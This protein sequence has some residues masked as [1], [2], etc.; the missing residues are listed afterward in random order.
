[1]R[2]LQRW[3]R[4]W[5]RACRGGLRPAGDDRSRADGVL[6]PSPMSGLTR[7]RWPRPNWQFV[8]GGLRGSHPPPWSATSCTSRRATGMV[9]RA[10]PPDGPDFCG[11]TVAGPQ[12]PIFF[13][14]NPLIVGRFADDRRRTTG[15][16]PSDTVASVHAFDRLDGPTAVGPTRRGR[17]VAGTSYGIGPM[18]VCRH[19]SRGDWSRSTIHSGAVGWVLSDQAL[20]LGRP[21]GR[22]G[23]CLRWL[24]HQGREPL[25]LGC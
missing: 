16:P 15:R 1:M 22:R 24:R 6:P 5:L 11:E 13:H 9:R 21:V 25:R 20:W 17:G 14:G 2:L 7:I 19:A 3:H 4:R 18:G 12:N 10:R 23:P 8:T